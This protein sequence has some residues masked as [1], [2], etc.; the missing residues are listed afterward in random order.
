MKASKALRQAVAV[1]CPLVNPDFQAAV[2]YIRTGRPFM[3]FV[4]ASDYG[5]AATLC[6]VDGTHGTP[7]PIAVLS[8]SFDSAQ[9]NW[10]PMQREM[11]ALYKGA[12]WAQK[13][14]RFQGVC[15]H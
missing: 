8:K 1:P 15:L 7:R 4:D 12:I 3:I 2:D 10:T 14:E 6:Q 5:Y 11:H 9:Q 13:F